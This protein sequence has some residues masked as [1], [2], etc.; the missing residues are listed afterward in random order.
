MALISDELYKETKTS[1]NGNYYEVD[2]NQ[3][4]CFENLQ[5]VSKLTHDI[6]KNCIL[7]PKCTW[8]SPEHNGESDRRSIEEEQENFIFSPP[9]IPEMWCHNFN[10]ALSYVWANDD[11]VQQALYVRKGAGHPPQEYKR[12]QCYEMFQRW[13]HYYPL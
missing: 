9:K 5:K 3:A 7:E 11:S 10:Y 6:N 8:A 1:C 2:P 12:R 4:E 13:I